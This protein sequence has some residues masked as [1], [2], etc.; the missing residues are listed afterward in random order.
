MMLTGKVAG[1]CSS[2]TSHSWW[3]GSWPHTR[4]L[5]SYWTRDSTWRIL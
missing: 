5:L 2:S 4:L 1:D 3:R